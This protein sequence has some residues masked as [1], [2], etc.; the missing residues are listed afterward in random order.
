MS[1]PFAAVMAG[2]APSGAPTEESTPDPND[3]FAGILATAPKVSTSATGAFLHAAEREAIPA[4]GGFVAAGAGAELGAGLGLLGGPFAPITVPVGTFLGGVGGFFL[5]Q[6]Y[7]HKVQDWALSSLPDSWKDALGQGEQQQ[8]LEEA[9][10]PTA[11]FLGGLAPYAVTMRPGA[12]TTKAAALPENATAFQRIMASPVTAR[13][14][15]GTVM[16]GMELGNEYVAGQSPDWSKV[17]I[18]TGFGLVFNKPTRFGEA[19]TEVGARPVRT[20]AQAADAKVIGPGVTEDVFL[21]DHEQA[22]SA[23]LTDRKSVV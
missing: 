10:H 16:G 22:P 13:L 5:G 3:P 7:T 19:I 15:G 21:G 18:S 11:S 1:D 12:F 20:L 8:R 23:A 4:A 17:A 14:F 6:H 2:E 9:Q